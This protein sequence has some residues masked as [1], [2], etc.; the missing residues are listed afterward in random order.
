MILKLIW[1]KISKWLWGTENWKIKLNINNY[2]LICTD[3]L[4][5]SLQL[6]YH[7]LNQF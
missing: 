4:K 7:I 5:I 6:V 3:D 2:V 1:I